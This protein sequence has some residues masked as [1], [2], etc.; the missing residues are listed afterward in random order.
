[1]NPHS[2]FSTIFGQLDSLFGMSVSKKDLSKFNAEKESKRKEYWDPTEKLKVED[3]NTRCA[4]VLAQ[5]NFLKDN[6][7]HPSKQRFIWCG[8]GLVIGLFFLFFNVLGLTIAAFTIP[9]FLVT[10]YFKNLSRD[11]LKIQLASKNNWLYDP[12][13]SHYKY[14]LLKSHYPE[15]FKKGNRS[16][17][18]DDQFWGVNTIRKKDYLFNSGMFYYS[19]KKGKNSTTYTTHYLFIKLQKKLN[20]EFLL[21]P[22]KK[23]IFNV[24]R[25]KEI[26]T[27]SEE[28][29]KLFEFSY[30]GKK[31]EK[32]LEIVKSL[33]PAVQLKLTE[34]TKKKG[35]FN[36]LFSKSTI[37]FLFNGALLPNMK[38]N[39]FNSVE[40]KTNDAEKVEKEIS[41]L[42]DLGASIAKYLN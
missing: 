35:P 26:N 34:L 31:D 21:S 5:V 13:P 2:Q 25:S 11:L 39:L 17:R 36:V 22:E 19:V 8:I 1:M 7:K 33:S 28:F 42:I 20:C 16:Q 10:F 15:I 12:T 40:I 14:Q 32:A 6:P 41:L 24:F 29:N 3:I 30:N 37:L 18:I 38:T 9:F 23:S 4:K 27:E